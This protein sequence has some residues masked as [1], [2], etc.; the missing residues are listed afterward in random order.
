MTGKTKLIL[1]AAAL[2]ALIVG[3]SVLYK[4]LGTRYAPEQNLMPIASENG[5]VE[6]STSEPEKMAAPDFSVL[7]S[8]GETVKLSDFVG[9]PIV[10]NFWASWCPPCKSEMPEF[11]KVYEELGED[12]TFM[13]VNLTDGA[14]ET[15]KKAEEY[16]AKEGFTFPVYFDTEQEAASLYPVSSIP[17]T[18]FIDAEGYIITGAQGAIDEEMLRRGIGFI[19]EKEE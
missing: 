15:K 5:S 16:V 13:M 11:N 8:S 18:F 14:R 10:I 4:T 6:G 2:V 9:K 17:T 12:V 7:D 1:S 19:Y 3:S